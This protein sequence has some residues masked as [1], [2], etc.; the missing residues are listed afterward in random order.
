MPDICQVGVSNVPYGVPNE[1]RDLSAAEKM[2]RVFYRGLVPLTQSREAHDQLAVN[3]EGRGDDHP[4]AD[5]LVHAQLHRGQAGAPADVTLH[6]RRI[7]LY[8]TLWDQYLQK[9]GFAHVSLR[10]LLML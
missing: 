9:Q 4:E 6:R 5:A 7:T 2:V 8:S 10:C 1:Y 3:E